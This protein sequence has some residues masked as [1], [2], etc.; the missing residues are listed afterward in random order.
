M[1]LQ[2]TRLLCSTAYIPDEK[3]LKPGLNVYKMN[4]DA[5][6]MENGTEAT[7]AILRN[8]PGKA[9]AGSSALFDHVLDA[10][11]DECLALKNGMM[12]AG[13]L[14][15]SQIIFEYDCLEVI[16]ACNG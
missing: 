4:V 2:Q 12:L 13:Q 8:H 14:G 7:A 15:C 6:S 16:K 5:C 1:P 10:P 3:W 9:L 11:T